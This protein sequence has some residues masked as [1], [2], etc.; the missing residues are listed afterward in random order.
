MYYHD[1]SRHHRKPKSLGGNGYPRNI[2][3]VNATDHM[4]WHRLFKNGTPYEIATKIN[5]V[6][7][8]PD[9]ILVVQRRVP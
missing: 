2:S 6:W 8:D 3:T 5:E 7:L 1:M 9:Y 4:A